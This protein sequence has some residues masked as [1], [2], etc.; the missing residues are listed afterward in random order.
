VFTEHALPEIVV[1]S[2]YGA[3]HELSFSNRRR[4]QFCIDHC[5]TQGNV[6]ENREAFRIVPQILAVAQRRNFVF[7]IPIPI[8]TLC[9]IILG[10]EPDRTANRPG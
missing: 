10:S 5:N 7:V 3:A 4:S 9:Q 8:R 2:P 6:E 1:P